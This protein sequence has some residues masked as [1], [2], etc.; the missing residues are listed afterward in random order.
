MNAD[1]KRIGMPGII[2]L[3]LLLGAITTLPFAGP[4]VGVAH[5]AQAIYGL[6]S[7]PE[8]IFTG[9]STKVRITVQISYDTNL[10]SSSVNLL[11]VKP[12]G[13]SLV[14]SRMYDDGTHGDAI[15]DDGSYSTVI[16]L[17]ELDPGT[18]KFRVSGG[19]KGQARRVLSDIF[20]L[21]V[22]PYP[23]LEQ[24][25]NQF[26]AKLVNKDMEGALLY[27]RDDAKKHYRSV[28]TEVGMDTV[29]AD[30]RSVRDFKLKEIVPDR[31]TYS[32][33]ATIDGK[34]QAGRVVFWLEREWDDI[35]RINSVGF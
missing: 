15:K 28:F 12:D 4:W 25:W 22:Q 29:A 23:N 35:W 16:D 14:V 6:R 34:D 18:V 17:N 2:A 5:A 8:M 9:I 32:F 10:V 30:F 7:N 27:M 11:R 1:V 3:L 26:V 24:I 31:A 21:E 19:Y 13:S 20:T 33:T